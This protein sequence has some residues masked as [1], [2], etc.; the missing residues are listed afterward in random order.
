MN[1]IRSMENY[2]NQFKPIPFWSWNDELD[3]EELVRQID[4]MN[5]NGIGGFFMHAR[6][7]LK[8]EYLSDKWFDCVEACL[9]R[10]KELN[11]EA[12]AYDE[13]GW[14]SGFVG[15]KLL[16]DKNNHDMFLTC[17]YGKYDENSVASYLVKD[18]KLTKVNNGEDNLNVYTNVSTSTVDICDKNIVKQFIKLTHEEY[19][20]HDRY[21]N[22]KG[23]FTDE[24]QYYRWGVPFTKQLIPY[25]KQ[26]YD[27]NVFDRIGLLFEKKEGYRDYRYKYYKALQDLMLNSYAKQVYEWCDSNGYKL[28]GHYVEEITLGHQIMCCGGVMPFYEY[29]HIPGVD[30][31]GRDVISEQ[32]TMKQLSSVMAQLGK[33]QGLCE[34]FACVG[35]DAT[36][37][38]LK[39]IA[40]SY[41]IGGNNVICHH[42]I[43]Y[44][45]HGQ[46]KRDYPEHYSNINPWVKKDF[47]TFNSELTK[48]GE[49]LANSK[50]VA[51]VGLFVPIR[52][53][54]FEFDRRLESTG[55]GCK[56]IDDAFGKLNKQLA[57]NGIQYHLLDE[58][59][60]AKHARVNKDSLIVGNCSYKYVIIPPFTTTM[61]KTSEK[62]LKEFVNNGGKILLLS[63]SLSYLEGQP[64]NY[65]YLRSNV[66]LDEII[67][68]K[69][70]ESTFNES[71][72]LSYRISDNGRP[73][74]YIVNIGNET[75]I[76]IKVEG[77][78][79]FIDGDKIISQK[80][81]FDRSQSRVL[82]FGNQ[83]PKEEPNKEV[84]S[85]KDDFD[86]V[87]E[88]DN[89]LTI[90]YVAYSLDGVNYS[91]QMHHLGAFNQLLKNRYQG[92]LYL[93][94]SFYIKTIPSTCSAL[95]ENMNLKEVLINGTKVDSGG[96]V[97]E[98]DL[99]NYNIVKYLKVG[100]NEIITKTNF[101]EN[102][103]VYYA[104]FG[105]N[106][107]ESIKNCLVYDTTI[108]S[109]FLKGNFGVFGQFVDGITQ[110]VINGKDFFLD[111]PKTKISSLIKDGYPFLRGDI[112]LSQEIYIENPNKVLV[113]D[114]RFQLIDLYI[115][116]TFVKRM[117]FDYKVD[118]S[119]YLKVGK[120]KIT[121]VL[122]VSN[123]NLLGPFHYPIEEPFSVGPH[124]FERFGSWKE[125]GS[126]DLCLPRYSF[127]K[128][129]I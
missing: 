25:F 68:D 7:G 43:P 125:D 15:G 35:W 129:I 117:M 3:P 45:E 1:V 109:I 105:E 34:M 127:V 96:Y 89:Y 57:D 33:K 94:Y 100:Q 95:I 6:G 75:D 50:E 118:L 53:A 37:I 128:T 23:F 14:P 73:F 20:K 76:E 12:Y 115:N 78:K 66:T 83:L 119:K 99:L 98:K 55:F 39:R 17:N 113:I 101:F 38:E 8:T 103:N 124:T 120:N 108:E 49:L 19:K 2:K 71:L 86:V 52:S 110:D 26:K 27:E 48:Y 18:N 126:S 24:P 60:M 54:Y 11:M 69:P 30:H 106:V 59:I 85:L 92:D 62:L 40:D 116:E 90:D 36:P 44:S 64:F 42:L 121:F 61:D 87:G 31:L 47:I 22:L 79:S 9:K 72:R 111:A 93:K 70:F 29:E 107:L 10:A 63:D 65:T 21:K 91:N 80:L 102:D 46:R 84:L 77:F 82:Y 123:R 67:K 28:T 81:H 104:L 114:K 122:T 58:T 13:N 112:T 88:V 74:I 4:W 56:E 41:S 32:L 16:E 97:L 51:D 5:Q